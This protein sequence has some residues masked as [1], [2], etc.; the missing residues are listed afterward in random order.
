MPT[1][2]IEIAQHPTRPAQFLLHHAL[3]AFTRS[4]SGVTVMGFAH[5]RTALVFSILVPLGLAFDAVPGRAA[6][7]SP[8]DVGM[9]GPA[10]PA[11][12][13]A[14]ISNSVLE[15]IRAKAAGSMAVA[16]SDTAYFA[17]GSFWALEAAFEGRSG[18]T[19]VTTGYERRDEVRIQTVEVVFDPRIVAYETLLDT[20]WHEI[21]PT[22]RD[23]QLCDL[24][25]QYRAA[26]FPRND[27]QRDA[28]L[29]SRERLERS[30]VLHAPVATAIVHAESFERAAS[31]DQDVF[32]KQR[33]RYRAYLA[34]C[35][36]AHRLAA[37]WP[38]PP[39]AWSAVEER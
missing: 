6:S 7:T 35:D 19:S 8:F 18:V 32:R 12:V 29:A 33:D 3:A 17:G 13:G 31:S 30:G 36:R 11:S 10:A 16:A 4:L 9:V 15:L 5:G 2:A 27:A 20:Y 23:G 39:S 28:A 1:G 25:P 22:Q 38:E 34:T 24:G 37:V 21:D 26:V 14:G